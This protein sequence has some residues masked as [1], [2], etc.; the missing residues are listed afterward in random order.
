ME[1]QNLVRVK[2][3]DA[4][5]AELR[6]AFHEAQRLGLFEQCCFGCIDDRRIDQFLEQ[7][8]CLLFIHRRHQGI[9][10]KSRILGARKKKIDISTEIHLLGRS[11]QKKHS[12]TRVAFSDRPGMTDRAI[13][14]YPAD[15]TFPHR[16]PDWSLF[17]LFEDE[18]ERFISLAGKF[19]LKYLR[20][21]FPDFVRDSGS[22]AAD[23]TVF[24]LFG[25]VG[26]VYRGGG[27]QIVTD[28]EVTNHSKHDNRHNQHDD[29]SG[30][31]GC[32]C[33]YISPRG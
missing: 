12:L 7:A 26:V 5:W 15:E 8:E 25:D 13:Q 19:I 4:A 2:S 24:K 9:L 6:P 17:T 10:V 28:P 21:R 14:T 18:T 3:I 32:R 1:K 23:G 29:A 16:D 11:C 33:E 27:R 22:V 30:E 20:Q 31:T